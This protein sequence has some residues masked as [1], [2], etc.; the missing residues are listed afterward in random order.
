VRYEL[1]KDIADA[2]T[3]LWPRLGNLAAQPSQD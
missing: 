1:F 2:M 3:P